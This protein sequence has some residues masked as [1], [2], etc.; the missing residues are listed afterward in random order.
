M[1]RSALVQLP[2]CARCG[3]VY[4]SKEFQEKHDR[5][6]IQSSN[7]KARKR[8]YNQRPDVKARM[9]EYNQRPDVK[10][11]KREY[12]QRPDVKARKREYNQRYYWSDER[13][14]NRSAQ[15][16]AELAELENGA[17]RTPIVVVTKRPASRSRTPTPTFTRLEDG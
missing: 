17:P 14:Q 12:Y 15:L 9:R 16:R 8:E 1:N 11:R 10:A 2:K 5:E 3:Q 13:I 4:F 6:C 7:V